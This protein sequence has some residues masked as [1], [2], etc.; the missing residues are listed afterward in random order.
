M[1]KEGSIHGNKTVRMEADVVNR[2]V[3]PDSVT[4]SLSDIKNSER[5]Q[6]VVPH[7][8]AKLGVPHLSE[9]LHM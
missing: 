3:N 4:V 7:R 6:N 8:I 9:T 2:R 1:P 5:Y